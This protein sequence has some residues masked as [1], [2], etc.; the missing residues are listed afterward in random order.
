VFSLQHSPR[1]L[2]TVTAAA[3]VLAATGVA[4]A[5]DTP[6]V[7]QQSWTAGA[8]LTDFPGT[9]IEKGEWI[10]SRAVQVHRTVT[11]EGRQSVRLTLRARPG[12]R[13]RALGASEHAKLSVVA[14]TDDYVGKRAVT[15]RVRV[16]PK[17]VNGNEVR[18]RVYALSR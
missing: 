12:Q 13:I 4:G 2:I 9:G 15:V 16:S 5:A 8:A 1:Q 11:L 17:A 14:L 3:T 18:E 10:G 6:A 7:S